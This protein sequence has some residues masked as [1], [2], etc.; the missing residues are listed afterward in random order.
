MRGTGLTSDIAIDDV[1]ILAGPCPSV[2][3]Y[4]VVN[5]IRA[6]LAKLPA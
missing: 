6:G 4:S 3:R 2:G 5:N 1:E